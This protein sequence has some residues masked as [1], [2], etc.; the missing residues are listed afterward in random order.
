LAGYEA[1]RDRLHKLQEQVKAAKS[2]V[3][4]GAGEL[5]NSVGFSDWKK[6]VERGGE[7]RPSSKFS[8]I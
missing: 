1:T 8:K 6:D 3:V 4:G 5:N 7:C 2:I